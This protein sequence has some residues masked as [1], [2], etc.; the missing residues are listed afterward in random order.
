MD[1]STCTKWGRESLTTHLVIVTASR[2]MATDKA[3]SVVDIAAYL[4]EEDARR[5]E[6]NIRT[7][8]AVDPAKVKA[9]CAKFD[10]K[11][12]DYDDDE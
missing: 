7:G 10:I 6:D 5:V 12:A 2:T 4:A 1:A 3:K 9:L 11:E 8:M